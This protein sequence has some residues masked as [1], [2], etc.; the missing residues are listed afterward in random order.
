[1]A[2]IKR[3]RRRRQVFKQRIEDRADEQRQQETQRLSTRYQHADGTIR[4]GARPA[5]NHERQK[6]GHERDG[7]HED[8]AQTIAG[9]PGDGFI[10]RRSRRAQ[11]VGAINL[12]DRVLHDD[13]EEQEQPQSRK[14]V[15]RLP[16]DQQRKESKGDDQRQRQQDCRRTP[17]RF[18]HR[19]Q[20]DVYKNKRDR[21]GQR[22]I[23][24]GTSE[25]LRSSS[26]P[27]RVY[28]GVGGVGR[29]IHLFGDLV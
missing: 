6:S 16:H 1:G 15:D 26:H 27:R 25:F 4:P 11:P 18:E 7:R 5:R 12:E 21:D 9:G 29:K 28:V 13:A 17:E 20:N 2:G 24:S 23:V 10:M 19:R 14:D 8:R 22:E 3:G